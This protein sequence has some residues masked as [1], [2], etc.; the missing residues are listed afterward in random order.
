MTEPYK[1]RIVVAGLTRIWAGITTVTADFAEDNIEFVFYYH[2]IHSQFTPESVDTYRVV[3][4]P[5][6]LLANLVAFVSLIRSLRPVHI[7]LYHHHSEPLTVMGQAMIGRLLGVPLVT[8]CTGGE[9]LYWSQHGALKRLAVKLTLFLSKAVL[10]K[11]TYMREFVQQHR[12]CRVEKLQF[13]HKG[14][15]VGPVP[16]TFENRPRTVLFLNTFKKWRH[17]DMI[18]RAVP[19]VLAKVSDAKF[20]LVG[21]VGRAHERSLQDLVLE[22]RVENAVTLLPFTKSPGSYFEASAVF[23]LPADVVF[24][25][26]A[27]LEAMERGVPPIVADVPG[28]E[29]IVEDGKSGL[30]VP[31]TEQALA[32]AIIK[33]LTDEPFRLQLAKGA[34][35]K[36]V[37]EYDAQSKARLLKDIYGRLIW[38]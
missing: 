11:E 33:L 5:P 26:N 21:L 19:Q 10:I 32:D 27:L 13:V 22:T 30:R 28:A 9:I 4:A 35:A 8:V 17:V 37:G 14:V 6:G 20:L 2:E 18:I 16:P 29:L 12:I 15:V 1:R 25:N 38:K 36:V 7:E 24:C 34:R 31:Q 3:T 23:L